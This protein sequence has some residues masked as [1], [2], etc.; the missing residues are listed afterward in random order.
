MLKLLDMMLADIK[1]ARA[2]VLA[3]AKALHRQI[4]KRHQQIGKA[5]AKL[6]DKRK[7]HPLNRR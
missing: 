1:T 4:G 6:E 5:I 2:D 3:E 7:R